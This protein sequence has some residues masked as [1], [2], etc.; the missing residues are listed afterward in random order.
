M[1]LSSDKLKII[2]GLKLKQFRLDKN[3]SLQELSGSSGVSASYLNEIEKGK[4][5]P[6]TDKIYSL[7]Q[8]LGQEYDDMVSIKLDKRLLPIAGFLHSNFINDIPWDFFGIDAMVLF[9]MLVQYPTRFST[10]VN[11]ISRIGKSYNLET[12]QF[13]FAILKSYQEVHQNYFEH[14]EKLAFEFKNENI[15]EDYDEYFLGKIFEKKYKNVVQYFDEF[16]NKGIGQLRSMYIAKDNKLL[17]NKKLNS[18]Q[19]AFV[20]ARE[21]GF[22]VMN[23]K[24]RP[25]TYNWVKIN[26]FEEILNNYYAS[27]FAS[28]V[29]VNQEK[30]KFNFIEFLKDSRPN[31]SFFLEQ[32]TFFKITPETYFQRLVNVLIRDIGLQKVFFIKIEN[33]GKFIM[34]KD[35]HLNGRHFPQENTKEAYC[36]RFN[37]I[38]IF[39]LLNAGSNE[40]VSLQ[41]SNYSEISKSYLEIS[42][43]SKSETSESSITVGIELNE[44]TKIKIGF[45]EHKSLLSK[46]L[47]VSCERCSIF[48]CQDRVSAPSILQKIKQSQDLEKSIKRLL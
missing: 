21:I 3:L 16:Q 30:M 7:S 23:L 33:E 9:D 25:F 5:Y 12:E 26:S 43:A 4:K 44:E 2:F 32:I 46:E 18:S 20:L 45:L 34:T 22:Q 8:A 41:V 15:T 11:A 24:I 1:N 17:I 40:I 10:F 47:G 36:R 13:Y 39:R 38:G 42:Y 35:L 31:N 28:C 6:K 19:R 29:V 48:N 27:Y 14:I 37:G